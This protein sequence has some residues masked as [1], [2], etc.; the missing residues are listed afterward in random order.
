M[1]KSK[2]RYSE[3]NFSKLYKN[4]EPLDSLTSTFIFYLSK[5]TDVIVYRIPK[6]QSYRIDKICK[7]HY[8]RT[9][10]FWVIYYINSI[11]NREDLSE[12]SYLLIPSL[13]AIEKEYNRAKNKVKLSPDLQL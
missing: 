6:S 12:G 3:V 10:L 8:K 11:M 13:S 9:D 2:D 5:I 7:F 1:D 4:D